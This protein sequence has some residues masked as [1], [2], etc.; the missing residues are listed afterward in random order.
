MSGNVILA[1]TAYLAWIPHYAVEVRFRGS[2]YEEIE[3]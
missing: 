1:A 2:D 3:R